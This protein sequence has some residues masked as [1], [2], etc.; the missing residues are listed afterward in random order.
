LTSAV[1]LYSGAVSASPSLHSGLVAYCELDSYSSLPPLH[2][3]YRLCR[4]KL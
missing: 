2:A 4:N 1:G 3:T